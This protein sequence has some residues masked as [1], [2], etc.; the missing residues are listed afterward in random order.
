VVGS[1]RAAE[2]AARAAEPQPTSAEPLGR[3]LRLPHGAG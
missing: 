3:A 2:R 1:T